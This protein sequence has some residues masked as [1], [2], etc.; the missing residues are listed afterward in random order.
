MTGEPRFTQAS[1]RMQARLMMLED[2]I[3]ML[4][5]ADLEGDMNLADKALKN[6]INEAS[7]IAGSAN[8]CRNWWQL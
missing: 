5:L 7:A 8:A 2:D 1:D 6:I 3:R 4:E